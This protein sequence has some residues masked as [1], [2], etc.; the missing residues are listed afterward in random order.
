MHQADRA[1]GC[2]HREGMRHSMAAVGRKVGRREYPAHFGNRCI[3]AV[4]EGVAG[5]AGDAHLRLMQHAPRHRGVPQP[6]Q[7]VPLV[8]PDDDE[9]GVVLRRV[10]KVVPQMIGR[11]FGWFILLSCTDG[12]NPA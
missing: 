12:L 4:R 11:A 9:I 10:R 3:G 5:N 6:A 8:S 1:T 7:S 2:E